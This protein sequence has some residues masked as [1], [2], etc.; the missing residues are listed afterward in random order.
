MKPKH[1]SRLDAMHNAR[2]NN[3]K[4]PWHRERVERERK[5]E[6]KRTDNNVDGIITPP[7][8]E[9][10][11][12]N[13]TDSTLKRLSLTYEPQGIVSISPVPTQHRTKKLMGENEKS[14]GDVIDKI[15]KENYV[16]D[17]QLRRERIRNQNLEDVAYVQ[18]VFHEMG[19]DPYEIKQCIPGRSSRRKLSEQIVYGNY[20]GS[21]IFTG[22]LSVKEFEITPRIV[23]VDMTTYELPTQREGY[24]LRAKQLLPHVWIVHTFA[25]E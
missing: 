8:Q 18:K 3:E 14:C 12:E 5:L 1:I 21:R 15:L 2:M 13:K 9:V 7:V 17:E 19:V 22:V 23:F 25:I 16:S 11:A 20:T 6:Q 24:S 4:P 10:K